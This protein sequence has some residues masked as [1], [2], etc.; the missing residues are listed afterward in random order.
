MLAIGVAVVGVL[1]AAFAFARPRLLGARTDSAAIDGV[2]QLSV[3]IPAR[4]EAHNLPLLLA[5]LSASRLVPAEVIVVDDHSQDTTAVV[6]RR[7][8]ARVLAAP[9][10]PN[11]WLGKSW[12]CHN[13]AAAARHPRLLFLDADTRLA[14]DA[15]M[16]LLEALDQHGGLVSVQPNHRTTRPF[17]QLSAMFNVVSVLGCGAFSARPSRV[18]RMAF[19]PCLLTTTDDYRASGGHEAVRGD[20]VEDIALAERY[21]DR[22]LRVTCRLGGD[23]LWFRMYPQGVRSLLQGWTKNVA[24]GAGRAPARFTALAVLW[25]AAA[26]AVAASLLVGLLGW[27][28]GGAAP[29][30]ELVAWSLIAAALAVILRR[31]GRF[32]WWTSVV[33]IVP[34][35][36]F[37]IVFA[38]SA[39]IAAR[40]STTIW[41]GRQVPVHVQGGRP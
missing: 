41:H 33:Y 24:V 36:W 18:Q 2:A 32:R 9:P 30:A 31:I 29:I 20:V 22:G 3:I 40:G 28:T 39:V 6:A 26:A 27:A 17:E 5:S 16:L 13:G 7:H 38:R 14:P 1:A 35:L 25:V 37:L 11:G 4:D 8:G 12:A 34:L 21:A 23:A 10:L 19:G 15:L